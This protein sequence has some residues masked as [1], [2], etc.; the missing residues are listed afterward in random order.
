MLIGKTRSDLAGYPQPQA[1]KHGALAGPAARFDR[2]QRGVLLRLDQPAL[3]DLL[4]DQLQFLA[5]GA[6]IAGMP[7]LELRLQLPARLPIGVA[8]MVVDDRIVRFQRYG[9]LQLGH[10][11]IVTPEPVIGPAKAVDD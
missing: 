9:A 2:V 3:G 7:P 1:R 10:R 8:E 5:L 4:Q 11:L 6:E